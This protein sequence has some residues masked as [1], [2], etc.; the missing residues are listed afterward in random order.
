MSFLLAMLGKS[1]IFKWIRIILF[2]WWW[3]HEL[4]PKLIPPLFLIYLR[5][6]CIRHV[7]LFDIFI[8]F[9]MAV[10]FV[11]FLSCYESF[12][13][14][15]ALE[16]IDITKLL[17]CFFCRIFWE[18]QKFEGQTD[19]NEP[20]Y[21]TAYS[22]EKIT[23]S[24]I[25]VLIWYII[26]TR[27]DSFNMFCLILTRNDSFICFALLIFLVCVK[28]LQEWV[29]SAPDVNLHLPAPNVFIPTDLSL[30]DAKNKVQI[31][32]H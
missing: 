23:S 26:L 12:H 28:L 2:Y 31:S 24:T 5:T 27:N 7:I 3:N 19:K 22:L 30:K 32:P 17:S 18:S 9:F 1:V 8:S 14:V 15:K 11:H 4:I 10:Y 6:R 20:W 21:N 16:S 25:Q 29:K 13:A